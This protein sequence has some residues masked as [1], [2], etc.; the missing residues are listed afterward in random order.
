MQPQTA[1]AA[2]FVATEVVHRATLAA[3]PT[4]G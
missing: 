3:P 1:E 2:E 4:S